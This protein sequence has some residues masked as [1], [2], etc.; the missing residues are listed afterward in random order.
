[1]S[2]DPAVIRTA[3]AIVIATVIASACVVA[4]AGAAAPRWSTPRC[5]IQ[6]GEFNVRHPHPT[7][8]QLAGG[9]RTLKRHGCRQ[10]VPGPKRWPEGKCLIYQAV[11]VK[12]NAFPTAK[13]VADANDAL[14]SH[15]CRQR[16]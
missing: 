10:R 4:R 13:Q 15:G 16:V 11:F 6:Q 9:N 3:T 7:G 14:G 2:H 12:L 5:Q 1:M 8:I